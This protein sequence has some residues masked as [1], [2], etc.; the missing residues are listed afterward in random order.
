[1]DNNTLI[2]IGLTFGAFCWWFSIQLSERRLAVKKNKQKELDRMVR[3]ERIR[4]LTNK[5]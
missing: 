1:M 5:L 4:Q 2:L 3:A